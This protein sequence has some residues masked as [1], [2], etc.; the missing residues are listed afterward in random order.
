MYIFWADQLFS[1]DTDEQIGTISYIYHTVIIMQ[2]GRRSPSC[3]ALHEPAGTGKSSKTPI[4]DTIFSCRLHFTF[5]VAGFGF[6]VLGF[7]F[8]VLGFGFWVLGFGF[9][10]FC[11]VNGFCKKFDTG[12]LT[13]T[14]NI[15]IFVE[16]QEMPDLWYRRCNDTSSRHRSHTQT[17][18]RKK[19]IN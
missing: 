12:F 4:S 7:G 5:Y 13:K 19:Q 18:T 3:I 1:T 17:A 15:Y 9:F 11:L 14:H 6:W 8:W 2:V 10:G 16:I